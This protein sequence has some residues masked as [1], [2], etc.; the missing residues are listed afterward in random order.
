LLL[1]MNKVDAD[2]LQELRQH[3]DELDCHQTGKLQ[4]EALVRALQHK[5]PTPSS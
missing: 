3:F 5:L 4:R 1:A 2:F